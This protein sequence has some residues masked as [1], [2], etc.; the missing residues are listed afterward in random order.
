MPNVVR[1]DRMA[2]LL[3]YLVGPGRS[4]EHTE[5]HPVA[6]DPALMAW[7]D[8]ELNRDAGLVIARHL[9]RPRTAHHLEVKGGHV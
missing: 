9:D 3:T 8:E 5:P 6:G 7:H 2:G 1:G 4:N